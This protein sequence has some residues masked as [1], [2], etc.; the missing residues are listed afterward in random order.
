MTGGTGSQLRLA[1]LIASLSLALDL[2][3]G[4]PLEYFLRSALLAV[5]LGDTLKLSEPDLADLY[6]LALL[7][8]AGCTAESHTGA[9]LF[10]DD[11]A[12]YAWMLL[13]EQGSPAEIVQ[14][15]TNNVGRGEPP[16][17]RTAMIN[18]ALASMPEKTREVFT[19]HCEVAQGMAARLGLNSV[20]RDGLG[21]MFER[22][23]GHGVPAGLKGEAIALPARIVLLAADAELYHRLGGT[24]GAVAVMRQRAGG[25]HDPALVEHFCQ[26]AP[27]ILHERRDGSMWDEVLAAEPG[28]RPV[29][30]AAQFDAA[31][32]AIGDFVDL[33]SP[34][35]SS[36]SAGVG[37]LAGA[38]ALRC[39]LPAADVTAIRRAG[40]VQD[41]GRIGISSGIWQKPGPLT[42]EEWERVR[43]HPYYTER[44]LSRPQALSGLGMLAALHHERLDGSGYHRGMPAGMLSPGARILAAADAYQAMTEARPHR[45]ALSADAAAD[46]LRRDV[47][48]GRLDGEAADAVLAAAGHRVRRKSP[49]RPAG[50]SDREVAVLRLVARG[51]SN[52]EIARE[53]SVSP[54]TIQHHVEH[55]FDK[56]G[57]STRVSATFY[58]MQHHLLA[59]TDLAEK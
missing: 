46:Q 44:V 40:F 43:L 29:V 33:K 50:L 55:I 3:L 38:A 10:G 31:A 56:T 59:D 13:V 32:R 2:G 58:A 23:D 16:R 45:P 39:G 53:L 26:V 47:R 18:R 37:D 24:E 36:H 22:W 30:S 28:P 25:A 1:E 41:L 34:Y 57:V 49:D 27:H 51:L 5:R 35:L 52:R 48:A 42:A 6:Y 14:A 19:S 54:R 12:F 4:Q 17:R 11:V 9:A 21:Q 15:L 7:R 20:V 8:H